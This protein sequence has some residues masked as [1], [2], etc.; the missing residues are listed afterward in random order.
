[1]NHEIYTVLPSY[2]V[3]SNDPMLLT[4]VDLRSFLRREI[5][6]SAP[7]GEERPDFSEMTEAIDSLRTRP[8]VR[9][10]VTRPG[11]LQSTLTVH[12]GRLTYDE[13]F[14]EIEDREVADMDETGRAAQS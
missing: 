3:G 11:C 5:E 14:R 9:F 10:D 13:Y 6:E 1:M 8:W 7:V 4:G 12:G 2:C